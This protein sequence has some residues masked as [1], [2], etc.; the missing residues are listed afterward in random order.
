[1]FISSSYLNFIL[2]RNL[3][4]SFHRRSGQALSK[5]ESGGG[6]KR[7]MFM[8]GQMKWLYWIGGATAIFAL[9]RTFLRPRAHLSPRVAEKLPLAKPLRTIPDVVGNYDIDGVSFD[10]EGVIVSGDSDKPVAPPI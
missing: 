6:R 1:M 9:M 3:P 2:P 8:R 5:H 7:R 10:S 4:E